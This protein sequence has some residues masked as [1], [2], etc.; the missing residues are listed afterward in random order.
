[1]KNEI[2][3]RLAESQEDK[4]NIFKLRF[5]GY[6]MELGWLNPR[7][8]PNEKESD[9]WEND[10][11]NFLAIE[12]GETIGTMRLILFSGDQFY[13]KQFVAFPKEI[14]QNLCLEVSRLYVTPSKRGNQAKV[15]FSLVKIA[16]EYSLKK[17]FLY[18]YF[19][20]ETNTE[21]VLTHLGWRFIFWGEKKSIKLK[22]DSPSQLTVRPAII[23][24]R[25][26][27]LKFPQRK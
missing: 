27:S 8:Y 4:D 12:D 18:W 15:M 9:E 23:D 22:D 24:L 25:D 13:T 16:K 26:E 21:K 20:M 17:G 2:I 10:S 5:K 1:M 14:P 11:Y 7:N 6:C 3:C 19:L